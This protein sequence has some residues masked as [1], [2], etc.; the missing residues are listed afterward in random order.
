MR[1]GSTVLVAAVAAAL[2]AAPGTA[3]ARA[4]S[5]DR[6]CFGAAARDPLHPCRQRGQRLR[7]TPTPNQAQIT[8]NLA[9]TGTEVDETLEQCAFG[10]PA[11]E[12]AATVAVIGDSHAAH[13]RAALAVVARAKRWRVLEIATPHCPLSTA[14]PDSGPQ[15]A[16][17]CPAWNQRVTAWLGEH[18]ELQTVF[19]SSHARAPI[20]VPA[21]RTEFDARVEGYERAWRSLPVSVERLIVIRDNPTDRIGTHACVRRAIAARKP[22]GRACAVLRKSVLP[23][24]AAVEAAKSLRARGARVID[25]THHF[26]GRRFCL[27]VVGGVLVHKDV[28]HLTQL[29]ARTL[30]PYLLRGVE[31]LLRAGP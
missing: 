23:P 22:A 26:C 17:F 19:L 6:Q 10:L 5:A 30:G 20:V 14:I 12:A 1:R 2:L 13:W 25:L 15:V 9:C 29:F 21:G 11:S 8:P 24:D 18:P 16:A 4:G 31:R 3:P 27:P 7:V 28:D